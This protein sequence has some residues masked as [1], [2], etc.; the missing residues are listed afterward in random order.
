MRAPQGLFFGTPPW[1]GF[2][3]AP[4]DAVEG[5]VDA[6]FFLSAFGFFF[7]RLLLCWPFAMSSSYG[8]KLH[9]QHRF[10]PCPSWVGCPQLDRAR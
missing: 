8:F 1:P 3:Q 5:A 4:V 10:R 2:P 9:F 6:T 7:S